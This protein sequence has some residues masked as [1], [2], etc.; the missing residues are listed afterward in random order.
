MFALLTLTALAAAQ[1]PDTPENSESVFG[2]AIS[3][4]VAPG[5]LLGEWP[6]P[7]VHGAFV[8]RYDAFIEPRD[9]PGVRMGLSIFG[10]A[11]VWPLQ[12]SSTQVDLEG[13]PELV[14]FSFYHFGALAILRY[15]PAAPWGGTFG[16]GFS[17]LDLEDYQGGPLGLPVFLL[18]GGARRRLGP[19]GL[20]FVDL[21]FRGGWGSSAGIEEPTEWTDWWLLQPV[22]AVGFN[23]K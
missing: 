2:S 3:A 18:E 13:N 5:V 23:L 14:P 11:S 15:A 22:I 20:A 16:V 17:R 8:L 19:D 12:D 9:A 4:G 21:M 10:G 1:A 6:E 7:G